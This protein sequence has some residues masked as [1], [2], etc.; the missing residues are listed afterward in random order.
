MEKRNVLIQPSLNLNSHR[1]LMA[2][3]WI[4]QKEGG[5]KELEEG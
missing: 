3:I 1:W 5:R 2:A 4:A